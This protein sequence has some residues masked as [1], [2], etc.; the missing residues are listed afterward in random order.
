MAK[1]V[2]HFAICLGEDKGDRGFGSLV[3]GLI[4]ADRLKIPIQYQAVATGLL[5]WAT[6]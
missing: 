3:N 6:F 4:G 2:H 5:K 1:I